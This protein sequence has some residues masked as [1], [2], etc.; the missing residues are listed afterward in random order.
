M[1]LKKYKW[2][3]F[4]IVYFLLYFFHFV[5][6]KFPGDDFIFSK[7]TQNSTLMHWLFN[8]YFNW[9]ARIFPD[10]MVYY[11]LAHRVWLWRLINPIILMLLCFSV[12]R[13]WRKKVTLLEFLIVLAILG[14]F[15]QNILSSGVFW[16]TGSMYYLWPITLGLIAMIPYADKVFRDCA[17]QNKYMF[18]LYFV[19]G[20]FAS[21]GN[22]QVSLC[23]SC[24]A[25]LTHVTLVFQKKEQDK[26]LLL[27]TGFMI[28]GTLIMILSPG[29]KVRSVAETAYWYPTF[30]E[31]SLKDHFYIGTIWGFKKIFSDMKSIL[32]LLSVITLI[33][34]FKNEGFKRN[35]IFRLF[36]LIF[37][38]VLILQLEGIAQGFL[39][40]FEEI[41]KFNFSATLLSLHLTKAFLI[42]V[43]PYFFWTVYSVM[44]VYLLLQ[45]TKF[46]TFTLFGFL[47]VI[48]TLMVMFFSPTIYGS[49]NRV[50][51]VGSVI[52]T[53]IIMGKIIENRLISNLFFLCII[54]CFP[55]I[56]LS[57]MMYRWLVHGFTP[58]LK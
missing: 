17:L 16:I 31:L 9:S 20:F 37:V 46:K 30:G 15:A 54:W 41:R 56:N 28:I 25:I 11:F 35:I 50:L 2:F 44:L 21:I 13:I 5:V 32:Y 14:Y 6:K 8:R 42:A 33:T 29:N 57:Y 34:Y 49:G 36:T 7:A 51:T 19:S 4:V 38:I 22:E 3:N 24:F 45:N 52:L 58:F 39:H 10:T 40:N 53:V 48:G 18:L 47:A 23:L 27:M 1:I 26:K 43:F 55:L 12:V